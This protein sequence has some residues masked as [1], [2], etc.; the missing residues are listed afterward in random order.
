MHNIPKFPCRVINVRELKTKV[1][2]RYKILISIFKRLQLEI[3]YMQNAICILS[4]SQKL[5]SYHIL[6]SIC[7]EIICF[8]SLPWMIFTELKMIKLSLLKKIHICEWMSVIKQNMKTNMRSDYKWNKTSF[9][10]AKISTN[11]TCLYL[12]RVE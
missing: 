10:A 8:V 1:I 5:S 7:T 9:Y 12:V 11:L 4:K 3:I 2:S 6:N